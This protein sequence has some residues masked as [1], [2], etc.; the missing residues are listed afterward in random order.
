MVLGFPLTEGGKVE[1]PDYFVILAQLEI[2]LKNLSQ[3]NGEF[4]PTANTCMQIFE[5]EQGLF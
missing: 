1:D 2:F 5:W 4:I 3:Y